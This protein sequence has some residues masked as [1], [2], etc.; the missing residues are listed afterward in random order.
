MSIWA[1]GKNEKSDPFGPL[2]SFLG[3]CTLNFTVLLDLG[4]ECRLS[5]LSTDAVLAC[6]QIIILS[7][8]KVVIIIGILYLYAVIFRVINQGDVVDQSEPWLR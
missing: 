1:L 3:R 5:M 4:E 2:F 7:V 8:I 6:L